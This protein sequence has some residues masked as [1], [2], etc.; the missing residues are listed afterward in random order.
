MTLAEQHATTT[1]AEQLNSYMTF[2][3]SKEG[4][5]YGLDAATFAGN[6]KAGVRIFFGVETT[7]T[8]IVRD[9]QKPE[10]LAQWRQAAWLENIQNDGHNLRLVAYPSDMTLEEA[11]DAGYPV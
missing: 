3:A 4:L 1:L 6:L 10:L 7:D 8:R 9:T 5:P 11:A 2:R